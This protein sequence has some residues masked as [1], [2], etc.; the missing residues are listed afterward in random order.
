MKNWCHSMQQYRNFRVCVVKNVERMV[1]VIASSI[2]M[3]NRTEI[4]CNA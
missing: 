1:S 2:S 4:Q 3:V